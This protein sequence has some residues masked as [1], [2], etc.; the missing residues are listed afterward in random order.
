M[1]TG[2]GTSSTLPP[3]AV[4][5]PASFRLN[6]DEIG[7]FGTAMNQTYGALGR[8]GTGDPQ[9]AVARGAAAQVVG[10]LVADIEGETDVL[11]PRIGE[12]IREE[13][14]DFRRLPAEALEYFDSPTTYATTHTTADLAG[15][16]LVCPPFASYAD[17][18]LDFMVEHPEVGSAAMT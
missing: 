7:P 11:V 16:G 4:S 5:N 3:S 6:A 8:L 10:S 1:A 2:P 13:I 12:R 14:P 15:S 17:R 9:L 18:L